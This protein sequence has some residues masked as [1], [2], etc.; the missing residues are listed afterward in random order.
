[1]NEPQDIDPQE[2]REWIESI[3]AVVDHDGGARAAYL[4]DR[5]LDRSRRLGVAPLLP[6]ET[7]Y[8]NT[9][10]VSQ[11]EDYPGDLEI[12][13]SLR[14]MMRWNAAVMVSRANKKHDGLGGHMSTY[15]SSST[16]LEVAFNHVF[17]GKDFGD[18][19][20]DHVYFQGHGSPG[21]YARAYMEG[22][23]SEDQLERFRREVDRG[24]GLSSYPHPRL[25]P[26]FWEYPTVSM[27]LGPINAIYQARFNRYL[28][29]R[30]IADTSESRVFC[31][32]GDGECDEPESLGALSI[33]A[34]E[35]LDNLTFAINCNLQRLDGPVRG[36]GKIVQELERIF[37]GAG[38]NVVKCLWGG[39]W[40]RLFAL[41]EDGY[42][43]E[44]LNAVVDGDLQRFTNF[45]NQEDRD[46]FFN[47]DPKLKELLERAG[48]DA[49][50]LRRGGHD[51][52]KVY[53]AFRAAERHEGR[54]SV[55]LFHTVKGY[56]LGA[57]FEGSN[58]THQMKKLNEE[59]TKVLQERLAISLDEDRAEL[60]PFVRPEEGSPEHRYLLERRRELGG[61]LP[62]RRAE[63][64]HKVKLP[65]KELYEEFFE[66][67]GGREI[68][69]TMAFVRLLTKLL[70]AEELGP[71]IVP[72]V[73]DESRTFGME[74][75]FRQI[76]IFAPAGQ[77]YEPVD[78]GSLMFYK[79][80]PDGQLL[81]EGINE[82]GG[83]ASFT[84]A[85]TAYATQGAPVMPF[86]IYYSMFG[87]QRV[88]D[89]I[90]SFADSRGRGFLLGATAGRTTLN[91]EGLQHEDGHSHVMAS[92]VPNVRAYDP[93]FAYEVAVIVKDGLKRMLADDEDVF[94]YLTLQN[95]NY[96]MPPAPEMS[97]KDLEEGI[98]KG[99]YLFQKAPERKILHVNL[100]GSAVMMQAAL[101]AQEIL[102]ERYGV[103]SDVWSVT[104]YQLLRNDALSC[105]RWNR[106]HP[107]R[108][109]KVP[110]VEKVA[111]DDT[112]PW[113]AV[114]DYQ[115]IIP[116]MIARWLPG[117]LV[118]L[119]TD[120]F[121]MSD[122]REALRRHF[123]VDKESVVIAA[124]HAL[125]EEGA[126]P[127]KDVAAA[128][129][130]LD[131]DADKI[132]PLDI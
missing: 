122:T 114:T 15:A 91:G 59:Q 9:V 98:V 89:L 24:Q 31:F 7:D 46:E 93:A 116:E 48:G 123:E 126:L 78:K 111:G 109:A 8:V 58:P 71:R 110:F 52:L 83:M 51:P 130:D 100:M 102:A 64:D 77:V 53:N 33:A 50:D 28:Q 79:E 99:M 13:Q 47:S 49:L 85:G 120:G 92:T 36:N 2:T 115:K 39:D 81:Q 21:L 41:D 29:A 75:L 38:W 45:E 66:G 30:G 18:G 72:I 101:A 80:S 95:D 113:I 16:F 40:D 67:S 60:N 32:M 88:G 56:G 42:L 74:A 117:R 104:S 14:R 125:S 69:S 37:R 65:A 129:K 23:L 106:L 62:E 44:K 11:E 26:E 84:A 73:P 107:T 97:A 127:P 4:L 132:D 35:R 76:G 17:R 54:P 86:Y 43:I 12:E 128:I 6:L 61:F 105:E 96:E 20:G 27:G 87:F 90:W 124:L 34:R 103:S 131:F 10:T 94:Y 108:K 118:P 1:M 82:A 55:I 25:M 19:R 22:R 112:A 63:P 3:E 119:G 57:S 5:V 121:G 70:K 68:S